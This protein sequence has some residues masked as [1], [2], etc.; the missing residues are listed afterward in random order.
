MYLMFYKN[1]IVY[2]LHCYVGKTLH[3]MLLPK[4][5]MLLALALKVLKCNPTESNRV[6]FQT[7]SLFLPT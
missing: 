4:V 1:R 3:V 2:Y 5:I 6:L 7:L